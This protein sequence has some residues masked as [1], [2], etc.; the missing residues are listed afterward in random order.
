M[1][2]SESGQ[3]A[4]RGA[5]AATGAPLATGSAPARTLRAVIFRQCPTEKKLQAIKV[6]GDGSMEPATSDNID[7]IARWLMDRG[8]QDRGA[9]VGDGDERELVVFWLQSGDEPE[10]LEDIVGKRVRPAT[11]H[12][13]VAE[14]KI[15]TTRTAQEI[16]RHR[17][18]DP[19]NSDDLQFAELPVRAQLEQAYGLILGSA[20]KIAEIEEHVRQLERLGYISTEE[21]VRRLNKLKQQ[22]SLLKGKV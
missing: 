15:A 4:A 12:Y 22:G 8:Y 10:R 18:R 21:C 2:C 16:K 14:R 7:E 6:L 5:S 13:V 9:F 1:S 20:E 3:K 11:A 17:R 19:N